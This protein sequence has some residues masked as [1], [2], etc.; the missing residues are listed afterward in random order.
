MNFIHIRGHEVYS[1]TVVAFSLD[2]KPVLMGNTLWERDTGKEA[3]S[4]ESGVLHNQVFDC[5][6]YWGSEW[7]SS[8]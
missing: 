2:E 5:R 6:F 3:K 4:A 7:F 8:P 1:G